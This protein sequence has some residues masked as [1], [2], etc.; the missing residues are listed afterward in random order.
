MDEVLPNF[1]K[2]ISDA[3]N[4]PIPKPVRESNKK[5]DPS[6]ILYEF[7]ISQIP[8]ISCLIYLFKDEKAHLS[9]L[10]STYIGNYIS[11]NHFINEDEYIKDAIIEESQ[12]SYAFDLLLKYLKITHKLKYTEDLCLYDRNLLFLEITKMN[13]VVEPYVNSIELNVEDIS[14][15]LVEGI[16]KSQLAKMRDLMMDNVPLMMNEFKNSTP[17]AE[18]KEETKENPITNSDPAVEELLNTLK[19][20]RFHLVDES[21][22]KKETMEDEDDEAFLN[23]FNEFEFAFDKKKSHHDLT[24]SNIKHQKN[25][26]H[27]DFRQGVNIAVTHDNLSTINNILE[28]FM[29]HFIE[30]K[31]IFYTANA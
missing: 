3:Y 19:N 11:S 7:K 29:N 4:L 6:M 16:E 15:S 10:Y 18:P 14:V 24:S 27:F 25:Y 8:Y 22:N 5:N 12:K 2:F 20:Q 26:C 30:I 13:F 28:S 31:T 17:K 21:K 23:K 9:R 1:K